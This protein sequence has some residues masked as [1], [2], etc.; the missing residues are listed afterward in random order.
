MRYWNQL[1]FQ[2]P[3]TQMTEKLVWYHDLTLMTMVG[4]RTGIGFFLISFYAS[5]FWNK[6]IKKNEKV[7]F[8][9]TFL[10]AMWLIFLSYP[11]L[12]NLF[13]IERG[14][15]VGLVVKVIGHQWYWSY[16]YLVR[17]FSASWDNERGYQEFNKW[18]KDGSGRR[19]NKGRF[20]NLRW[21]DMDLTW[22]GPRQQ[23]FEVEPYKFEYD[24]FI[25]EEANLKKGEYRLLEVDHRLVLPLTRVLLR[26][27]S[28]DVI[29]RWSVPAIGVKIDA[30][31]GKHNILLLEPNRC[32]VFYGQC[33]ELCGVNHSFM[34]IVVEV[35]NEEWF[36]D[37]VAQTDWLMKGEP[38]H[39][40]HWTQLYVEP[41]SLT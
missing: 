8:W 26:I 40:P 9:W 12:R 15:P 29:H 7:E 41:N 19:I 36:N 31:P 10:P 11:S 4:L 3:G 17:L 6:S 1:G 22:R 33:A 37:W 23:N 27:T 5:T 34:P 21:G 28:A 18:G 35:V 30:V 20:T 25:V 13:E 14:K 2:D 16:E 24:S 39:R 38:K 32:G